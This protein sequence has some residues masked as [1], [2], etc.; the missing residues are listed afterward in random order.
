MNT[1]N[2]PKNILARYMPANPIIV[3]AGAHIGRDSIKMVQIWPTSTIHAF[4]PVPA[5]FTQLATKSASYSN[6]YCYQL[7]LS[8]TSGIRNFFMSSGR[9]TATS[10]L[11]EPTD[12]LSPEIVFTP[13]EVTTITLD[14]WAQRYKIDKI[15]FLWLDMQG[16]ELS[17][18]QGG[19]DLI[20]KTTALYIEINLV[21]RYKNA[22]LYGEVKE[23]L[24]TQ[25]FHVALEAFDGSAW[26]NVLFTK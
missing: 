23:W 21:Q 26:G 1:K 25:G 3:E 9:S 16:G 12:L 24:N 8:N 17:A 6:I 18:L 15:D 14:Q 22:P 2:I 10:S 7:A 13:I 11:L 19:I 20:R 5:L 4:E